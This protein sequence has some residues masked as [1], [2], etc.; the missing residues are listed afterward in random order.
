MHCY[1]AHRQQLLTNYSA[2]R[3]TWEESSAKAGVWPMPGCCF[4]HYT[5][6][7]WG[8]GSLIK[9]LFWLTSCG[10]QPL[11]ASQTHAPPLRSSD[12][13][14]LVVPHTHL[15]GPSHFCCCWSV[16]LELYLLT[17]DCTKTFSL[18]NATWKPISSNSLSPPVLNQVPLYLRT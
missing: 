12:A 18:S 5:G 8:S 1:V 16:H 11:N 15:T 10:P 14:L 13:P 2:P 17:F 3:T 6:F 7:R 9:W 4:A